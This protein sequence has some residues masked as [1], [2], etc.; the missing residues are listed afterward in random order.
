M[1]V[2]IIPKILWTYWH[3]LEK[4]PEFVKKCI[5]SWRIHNSD[6]IIN[7]VTSKTLSK[8]VGFEESYK[9]KHW[10]FM[11]SVQRMSDLV[12]LSVLSKYGGIWLDASCVCY[13]SFDWVNSYCTDV[14]MYKIP[15]VG[16]T[17]SWFIACT[18]ENEYIQKVNKEFREEIVKFDSIDEYLSKTIDTTELDFDFSYL[19]IYLVLNKFLTGREKILDA[20]TGPYLYQR[21]GGIQTIPKIKKFPKFFKFRKDER[22]EMTI[23]IEKSIFNLE[24]KCV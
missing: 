4:M 13:E 8:Y 9:I 2:P 20:S 22:S 19:V 18:R 17:E 3:S 7:V 16:V 23:E 11:D 10:K 5:E 6:Y 1:G 21:L 15:E 14:V 24:F 12:R